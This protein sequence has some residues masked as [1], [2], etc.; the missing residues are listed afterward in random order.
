MNFSPF[1]ALLQLP[2]A[3]QKTIAV[4]LLVLATFTMGLICWSATA[5]ILNLRTELMDGKRFAGKLQAILALKPSLAAGSLTIADGG[6]DFLQGDSEAI[7]RGNLPTAV[8][9]LIAEQQ[10]QLGQVSNLPD[11]EIGGTRYLGIRA[12]ISGSVEAVY[13][14]VSSIEASPSLT[15]RHASVWRSGDMSP[16]SG[17]APEIAAQFRVYGALPSGQAEKRAN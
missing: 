7:A 6:A 2:N 14:T 4:A 17:N 15:I 12:D 8:T 11:L 1:V 10:A 13:Q 5:T 3:R 9:A 16:N